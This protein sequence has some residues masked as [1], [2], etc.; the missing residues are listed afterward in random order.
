MRFAELYLV[1]YGGFQD[2]ILSFPDQDTDFHVILGANEA[3]KSTSLRAL[4]ALLFGFSQRTQDA[5]KFAPRDLRVGATLEDADRSLTVYRKRGR[6]RT[7]ISEDDDPLANESLVPYLGSVQQSFFEMVFGLNHERLREGGQELAE[8]KG[9]LAQSLFSAG[10][11]ISG[12]RKTLSMLRDKSDHLFRAQASNPVINKALTEYKT[13]QSALRQTSLGSAEWNR[14]SGEHGRVKERQIE[15]ELEIKGQSEDATRFERIQHNLPLIAQVNG[16]RERLAPMKS[17]PDVGE[18]QIN[19]RKELQEKIREANKSAAG[20]R[21]EIERLENELERLHFN[22]ALLIRS[23]EVQ[24]WR[25]NRAGMLSA[26]K[27][28]PGVQGT[29]ERDGEQIQNLL[30]DAALTLSV[31]GNLPGSPVRANLRSLA[32][33]YRLLI[34]ARDQVES[35][36]RNDNL[37][38]ENEQET[39]VNLPTFVDP[40]QLQQAVDGIL[41]EG[42]LDRDLEQARLD[43]F[44]QRTAL[45][46]RSTDLQPWIVDLNKLVT[47]M[48]PSVVTVDLFRDRINN[49]DEQIENHQTNITR[50]DATESQLGIELENLIS[51]NDLPTAE[52]LDEARRVRDDGWRLL[53]K[54]F[55][56]TSDNVDQEA[57][58]YDADVSLPEAFENRLILADDL[59]DRRHAE[60]ERVAQYQTTSLR[61]KSVKVEKSGFLSTLKDLQTTKEQTSLEWRQQWTD[62]IDEPL[63][64]IEMRAWLLVREQVLEMN[65]EIGI[66]QKILGRLE[67]RYSDA[68]GRISG[69]LTKF[70]LALPEQ[71]DDF[72]LAL[73][74][75]QN[76]VRTAAKT[77]TT[78]NEV[79]ARISLL[80]RRASSSNSRLEDCNR[81]IVGWSEKWNSAVKTLERD[82]DVTPAEV[83]PIIQNIED[84][85]KLEVQRRSDSKRIDDM[86]TFIRNYRDGVTALVAAAEPKLIGKDS[87]EAVASMDADLEKAVKAQDRS[88][89]LRE[90]ISRHQ[91]LKRDSDQTLDD[92]R[93][94][95]RILCSELGCDDENALIL[96]ESQAVEKKHLTNELTQLEV[97][98]V[99][100]NHGYSLQSIFDEA[101]GINGDAIPGEISTIHDHQ[102][103]LKEELKN[104]SEEVGR[105]GGE[106]AQADGNDRAARDLQSSEETLAVI[107]IATAEYLRYE[108][109][110]LLLARAIE[111]YQKRNQGPLL[112]RAG[113]VFSKITIGSF[114]GLSV[115][116][117]EKG[118]VLLGTRADGNTLLLADMS[119]GTLDQLYL[120]LRI[121][122]IEHHVEQNGPL[123]VVLDDILVNFDDDRAAATLRVL[124]D[125]SRKTQILF[126]SHHPHLVTAA[127]RELGKDAVAVSQL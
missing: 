122:A 15:L 123:P 71:P 116:Y 24:H 36:R 16:L 39:I 53:R 55:I 51:T 98:L 68:C 10:T 115:D 1:K 66:S 109:A 2:R 17:V 28:L 62:I 73:Q 57:Q 102:A 7:L 82:T 27:D 74:H 29:F 42:P 67:Q 54:G 47:L 91:D 107:E 118:P 13:S 78:Y 84:I 37:E 22:D 20:A 110:H 100:G 70:R 94:D 89:K 87:L 33:E 111:Q 72:A 35:T 77:A 34:E 12:L 61:L 30:N 75:I 86:E 121:A 113:E 125:L 45:E 3:G 50:L 60:A 93:D 56:D 59:A 117:L 40:T 99:Q 95:L 92:G 69:A 38:L 112:K 104:V 97:T 114:A 65:A 31:P 46:L 81:Q 41:N 21:I 105:L 64:P 90:E 4:L 18:E 52:K 58:E 79:T 43:I 85:E 32:G 8:N 76:E 119:D 101:E 14:L 19:R 127:H 106:L 23:E 80:E 25:D 108:T 124:A 11:G 83:E 26:V 48:V 5:Y 49:H 103:P 96:V 120:S 44:Q 6:L 9:D 88:E 126:L 63:T